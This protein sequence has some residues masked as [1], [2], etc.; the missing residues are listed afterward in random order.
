[1]ASL[2][3]ATSAAELVRAIMLWLH[4]AVPGDL[5]DTRL[6][7]PDG[8]VPTPVCAGPSETPQETC[9]RT[10]QEWLPLTMPAASGPSTDVA[11]VQLSIVTPAGG[12]RIWRNPESPPAA[13][14]LA[15]RAMARPHV[16]QVVW[17]VDG[18]PFA[19]DDPDVTVIWPLRPGEHR[20][21]IGLPL[22]PE[23]SRPVHLT[24]E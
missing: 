17:Y 2:G 3:G 21:Q 6:A 15:L 9:V 20:F 4:Q 13:N 12:T 14:G 22:Q 7:I 1:M 11:A 18:E 5:A 16:P 19:L 8:Y 23:R 24:V 10:L